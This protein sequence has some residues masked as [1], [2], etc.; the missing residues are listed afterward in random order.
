MYPAT[1][2]IL[3][4]LNNGQKFTE[5]EQHQAPDL[6]GR[7]Q[8][9]L[10]INPQGGSVDVATRLNNLSLLNTY[11]GVDP[12]MD[13]EIGQDWVT[14]DLSSHI[15]VNRAFVI[16]SVSHY[17]GGEK[18]CVFRPNG[19]TKSYLANNNGGTTLYFSTQSYAILNMMTGSDG[20]IQIKSGETSFF[21]RVWVRGWIK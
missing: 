7:I 16:L 13:A 4:K 6:L 8:D 19:D 14:I 18:T 1:K 2:E 10:G 20:K 9:T 17:L 21:V 15:G 3:T 5:I 11:D 12:V